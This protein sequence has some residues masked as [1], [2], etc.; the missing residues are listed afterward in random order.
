ML[1]KVF[2]VVIRLRRFYVS[3]AIVVINYE[4]KVVFTWFHFNIKFTFAGAPEDSA[5]GSTGKAITK[6][7][8]RTLL[9]I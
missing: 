2:L 3:F 7:S 1:Y 4:T 5:N 8:A 9:N 6:P